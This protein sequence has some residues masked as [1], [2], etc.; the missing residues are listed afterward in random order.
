MNFKAI[1]YF[2]LGQY[3]KAREIYEKSINQTTNKS[4]NYYMIAETYFNEK[5]YTLAKEN[6]SKAFDNSNDIKTK[7]DSSYWLIR[8]EDI[9]GNQKALFQRVDAFRKTFPNS[10]YDEDITYLVAKIYEDSRD[11]KNAINEYSKLYDLTQNQMTKD[12]MAK[13][14]TELYYEEKDI[15]NSYTWVDRV[16]ENAY[17]LLWKG[18][19]L[20]LEKKDTDAIKNYEKIVDDKNYGDSANYKLGLYYLNKLDYKKA[21]T[22]F[23]G[24]MNFDISANKERAQYNIGVTYEKEGDYLKAISSFLR[25]KLLM[26]NS[27]L[28]DLVLLK[29]AEDYEKLAN[30]DKAF[31]YFKEYFDKYPNKKDYAYAVEKLVVNRINMDKLTEAKVYYKELQRVNPDRAK[32]Y[33]DYMK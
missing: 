30:N 5:N 17:K 19:I 9:E 21:R 11:R 31:E 16:E 14:I 10:E 12:E 28:D 13:R 2:R 26:E 7:K 3:V 6:Y 8:I 27:E 33:A 18:Y 22:Y 29:L 24:V 20:E 15:K 25:I 4:D 32:I 23:E 1:A